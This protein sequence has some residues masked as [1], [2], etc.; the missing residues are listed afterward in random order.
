MAGEHD[1]EG[2]DR[3]TPVLSAL[4]RIA[5]AVGSIVAGGTA[6]LVA[7][8]RHELRR[9]AAVLALCLAAAIFACGAAGFAAYSILV[10]LGDEHRVAGSALIAGCFALLS[11]ICVLLARG[12]PAAP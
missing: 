8:Q 5:S 11:G 7:V 1:N 3:L 12:R 4:V 10:A 6:Q 2:H 9:I